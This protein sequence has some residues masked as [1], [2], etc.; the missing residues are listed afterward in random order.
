VVPALVTTGASFAVPQTV[1]VAI[2]A[3]STVHKT[4]LIAADERDVDDM[5]SDKLTTIRAQ[6]AILGETGA[7]VEAQCLDGDIYVVGEYATP[8]DRESVV[9]TLQAVDGVKSVKGVLK[10]RPTSLVALVEPAIS[11]THAEMVIET[12]L[13]KELHIKSANVD[14]AVVQGEA[15]VMGVVENFEEAR[16]VVALV[17]RLRPRVS[18]PVKVTSLLVIQDDFDKGAPQANDLF[19]L[20]TSSQMLAAAQAGDKDAVAEWE[21]SI[22]D[23]ETAAGPPAVAAAPADEPSAIE[24]AQTRLPKIRSPWQKARLKMKRRIL[25]MAKEESNPMVRR[26]LITLSTRVL[27]DRN[28]SIEDR[29]VK[30]LHSSPNFKIKRHVNNILAEYAPHRAISFST[31][32]MR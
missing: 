22:A 1:S 12:G 13:L 11:D 20:L 18:H 6:A 2:S 32:A 16:E 23:F 25:S 26:R 10:P 21:D 19:V 27:K 7:E 29:L 14:V 31:V 15:V 17:E 24:V 30:T 4:A 8:Q 5:I 9:A 3:A 28:T